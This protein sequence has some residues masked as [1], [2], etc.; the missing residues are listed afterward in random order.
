MVICSS[1]SKKQTYSVSRA[2]RQ[3]FCAGWTSIIFLN[4]IYSVDVGKVNYVIQMVKVIYKIHTKHI[5][6]YDYRQV[7]DMCKSSLHTLIVP[8]G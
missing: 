7:L 4:L 1:F 8:Y 6:I 3:L 2:T 5:Y